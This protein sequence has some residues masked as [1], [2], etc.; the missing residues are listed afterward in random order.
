[1]SIFTPSIGK[2]MGCI[3]INVSTTVAT[4]E[5]MAEIGSKTKTNCYVNG[6]IIHS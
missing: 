6:F 3:T 4:L 1:M 2:A 5:G